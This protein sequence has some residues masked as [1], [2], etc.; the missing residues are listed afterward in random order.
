MDIQMPEMDGVETTRNLRS[1]EGIELAPIVAMT[2]YS[3]KEDRER[4]LEAG[5]DDYLPKPIKA[6]MLIRKVIEYARPEDLDK[7]PEEL[8]VVIAEEA[9]TTQTAGS[10]GT[11]E[12]IT[13]LQEADSEP[14]V[15]AEVI[16][17][18]GKYGGNDLI[19][20]TLDEFAVEAEGF[21]GEMEQALSQ[22]DYQDILGKLH[23]LKGN[24]GTL[25]V[26]RVATAAK[27]TEAKLKASPEEGY[28]ELSRDL[29]WLREKHHEFKNNY[30]SFLNL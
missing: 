19:K 16:G 17:Q 10:N 9:P 24:A 27:E 1:M 29:K 6:N 12:P 7:T 14:I 5:M 2:A 28:P 23:T 13:P 21:L 18:L 20:M 11:P 15:D 4:F 8:N 26:Q 22:Q 25:G 30:L 3:M